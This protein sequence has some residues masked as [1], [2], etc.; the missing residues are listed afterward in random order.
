MDGRSE[1]DV[2]LAT[3]RLVMGVSVHASDEVGGV[4]P[5]QLRALTVLHQSEGANLVRLSE[6]MAVTVSTASRLVDRLVAAGLADRRPSEL[7]RRE[8]SLALTAAGRDVLARYDRLRVE[9]LRARLDQLADD[10]RREV[11]VALERLV[12]TE[13]ELGAPAPEG[14][15]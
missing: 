2:L 11:L 4:S 1:D 5:V 12:A 6:A 10:Q 8:I 9:A 7:T 3:A 13:P 15:G 14:N